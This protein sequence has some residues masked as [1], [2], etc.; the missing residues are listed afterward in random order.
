MH[1][2]SFDFLTKILKRKAVMMYKI[3][4]TV[5]R[6]NC[7]FLRSSDSYIVNISF[8][9]LN[10]SKMNFGCYLTF[11]FTFLLGSSFFVI[12]LLLS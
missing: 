6:K 4:N 11:E 3:H 5:A 12:V 7:S 10:T 1:K 9:A 8:Y 2:L